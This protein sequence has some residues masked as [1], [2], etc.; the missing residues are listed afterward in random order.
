[1]IT[2]CC[3]AKRPGTCGWCA[4]NLWHGSPGLPVSV[5]SWTFFSTY[6]KIGYRVQPKKLAKSKKLGGQKRKNSQA[7]T[8]NNTKPGSHC[9]CPRLPGLGQVTSIVSAPAWACLARQARSPKSD[10]QQQ[11]KKQPASQPTNQPTKQ[12][13][14][15]KTTCKWYTYIYIYIYMSCSIWLQPH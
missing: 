4:Q 15:Q 8:S 3:D 11:K 14:K 1:M 6:I 9:L 5:L 10:Q 2:R 13:N 7:G 12:T